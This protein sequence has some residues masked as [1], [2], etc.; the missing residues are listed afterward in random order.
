MLRISRTID[1]SLAQS[2]ELIDESVLPPST[3]PRTR[4]GLVLL[5]KEKYAALLVECEDL[6]TWL[7]SSSSSP[8]TATAAG[9]SS[10]PPTFSS[11]S[12]S[13]SPFAHLLGDGAGN[14]SVQSAVA[15]IDAGGAGLH[16]HYS[17]L[18][19]TTNNYAV[20]ALHCCRVGDAMKRLE[21]RAYVRCVG[22]SPPAH[23]K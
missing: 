8:A 4:L 10:P 9:Q 6:L 13:S 22:L 21:V 7:S 20:A 14:S 19:A 3:H 15:L 17:C 23:R 1:R 16:S 11:S 12:S 2:L 5:A 18:A